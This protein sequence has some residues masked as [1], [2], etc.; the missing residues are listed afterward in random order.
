MK[1]INSLP[2]LTKDNTYFKYSQNLFLLFG[3]SIAWQYFSIN[4]PKNT[5]N[6]E[7]SLRITKVDFTRG[8][9]KIGFTGFLKSTNH[10]N[11]LEITGSMFI[12]NQMIGYIDR[13]LEDK[14]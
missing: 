14:N 1:L 8:R 12:D 11:E 5:P 2:F 13:I 10:D 3:Q 9:D 6:V 7:V 4:F